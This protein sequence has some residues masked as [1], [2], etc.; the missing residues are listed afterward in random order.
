[1]PLLELHQGGMKGIAEVA[2]DVHGLVV[3]KHDVQSTTSTCGLPL[4]PFQKQQHL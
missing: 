4:K 1:M 3:A 2:V